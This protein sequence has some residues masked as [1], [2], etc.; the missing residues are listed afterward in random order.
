MAVQPTTCVVVGAGITGLSAAYKLR[1]GLGPGA[2]IVVMEAS[3]SIGGKLK[4]VD[5]A[6]G[7]LEVGAEAYLAFRKDATEFFE[8]LG[9]ADELV[10]P[11][12]FPSKLYVGGRLVSMPR[13]TAMGIPASSAGLEEL[14]TEEALGAIDAEGDP[15]RTQSLHWVPGDDCNLG[16]L[17][18]ARLGKEVVDRIVSPL[19]GGVYSCVAHDLGLRSTIPQLALALD[20][21]ASAGEFVSLT[22]AAQLV[23]DSRKQHNQP[24]L[25][26]ENAIKTEAGET[27]TAAKP[28]PPVVFHTFRNGFRVVYERL[29]S[30]SAAEV[31]LNT[32]VSGI[33]RE[34]KKYLVAAENSDGAPVEVLAD[35]VVLAAPAPVTGALLKNVCTDASEIIGGVDLASSAVVALRFDTDAGLPEF[36]GILCETEADITAKAFTVS[37]RK[38]PHLGERGGAVVRAS[39]GRFGQEELLKLSDD[40][41][42]ATALADLKHVSGFAAPVAET[43]VQRWWGGI[44]RYGVGHGDLMAFADIALADVPRIG[45]AGAWHNGPGIPACL[46]DSSAAVQKVIGELS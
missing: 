5:G 33:R 13:N 3:D 28:K 46:T 4:T 27:S 26:S 15:A 32:T 42:V 45:V 16:Q 19:L 30:E 34:A 17:V 24:R 6:T 38:W 21:L 12:S 7:P 29:A 9:L 11:S 31:M 20:S 43:F 36:N 8:E 18:E 14:L 1:K 35:A 37:S 22:G 23:L 10:N 25:A 44:P 40:E 2:R 39:F 41:L